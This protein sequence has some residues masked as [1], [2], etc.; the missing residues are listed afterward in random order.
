MSSSVN[1]PARPPEKSTPRGSF[2]EPIRALAA[3]PSRRHRRFSFEEQRCETELTAADLLCLFCAC[4]AAFYRFLRIEL[5]AFSKSLG[6][7]S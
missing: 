7:R 3:T 6:Q 5:F 4:T 2:A 1:T